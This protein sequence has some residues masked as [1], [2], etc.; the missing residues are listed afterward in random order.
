MRRM[1][2]KTNLSLSRRT[3]LKGLGAAAL[4][5]IGAPA[6][7]RAAT[8][9]PDLILFMMGDVHSGYRYFPQLVTTIKTT[10]QNNPTS[11]ARILI[12]GDL[13]ES[14]NVLSV[15]NNA[16]IDFQLYSE[17]GSLAPMIVTLGNHDADIF[18][19]AVFVQALQQ[20]GVTVVTNIT[21][22]RTGV[23]FA[24]AMTS[25]EFGSHR[26]VVAGF[27]TTALSTY[28]ATWRSTFNVP[29]P[30]SWS[31]QYLPQFAQGA[32]LLI[33][34][35]HAGF[36]ADQSIIAN[37]P[38]N[39]PFIMMGAHDH[40]NFIQPYGRNF[41]LQT[42][43][44]SANVAMAS[45]WFGRFGPV[46]Q[47]ETIPIDSTQPGDQT[48]A[49]LIAA[50]KA[51]YLT[52]TDNQVLGHMPQTLD[53]NNAAI[54]ALNAVKNA[55]GVDVAMCGNTTFGDG[56]HQGPV[57]NFD[58][59][60]FV[61]FVSYFTVATVDGATLANTVLPATNQFGNFPCSKRSSGYLYTTP[62]TPVAGTSYKVAVNT[63][64]TSL[65]GLPASAFT[66]L[67]QTPAYE[68]KAIASAS[69]PA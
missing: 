64:S 46:I 7:V 40:L 42:G 37:I 53:V 51:Q 27:G 15:R 13:N 61:R 50:Q 2:T 41:H 33:P 14:G 44:W 48:I 10:L 47:I 32:S 17:L 25:F 24:P 67:P 55:L 29:S 21:D 19:A 35:A 16:A 38:A 65:T 1:S 28:S 66:A 56:L 62:I 11:M 4:P 34:L 30:A 23:L 6:L 59:A 26:V 31:A 68:L 22:T 60:S 63:F 57:T 36:V 18:D 52:A 45:V 69:I 49:N 54:F 12:A 58:I 3:L 43:A 5:V 20:R 39:Q 9:S 8:K